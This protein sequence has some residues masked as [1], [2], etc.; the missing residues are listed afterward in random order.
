MTDW[1]FHLPTGLSTGSLGTLVE[2]K[3]TP[4]QGVQ[5]IDEKVR[6][7]RELLELKLTR[8]ELAHIRDLLSIR[9]P[10]DLQKTVSQSLAEKEGR[11]LSEAALWDRVGSLCESSG[12][13]LGDE[14]PDF[15]VGLA[16][17]PE[18]RVF[19]ISTSPIEDVNEEEDDDKRKP[20]SPFGKNA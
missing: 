13:P 10:P 3:T 18:M 16:G 6:P 20:A 2:G 7:P 1:S 5:A 9:L 8:V 19:E 11:P 15:I 17:L 4:E 14:A 12:V